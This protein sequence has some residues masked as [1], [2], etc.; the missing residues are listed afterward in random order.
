MS[1][2]RAAFLAALFASVLLAIPTSLDAQRTAG[3]TVSAPP[4]AVP[5]GPLRPVAVRPS[6]G[7]RVNGE[8]HLNHAH[9]SANDV[10]HQQAQDQ[11][12]TGLGAGA[13]VDLQQLLNITPTNGF[14]WQYV[15][16]INQDLP[17][18]AIVDPVTRLEIAQAEQLLRIGGG[19][20]SG[21]YILDGGYGYY[22]P[23]ETADQQTPPN[24]APANAEQPPMEAQDPPENTEPRV[25]V[26]QQNSQESTPPTIPNDGEFTLVL[27][28]GQKIAAV[29]FTRVSNEIVYITP[30]GT[31]RTIDASELD[32]AATVRLNQERGTP[33]QLPG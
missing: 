30:D 29:A 32:S 22:V 5:T 17:L 25:I 28:N 31:R 14:D 27:R 15:N 7:V 9:S 10:A 2:S 8:R 18:K 23:E 6:N 20:F 1:K 4:R 3:R 26:L 21:A 24:A 33:L 16:A 13:P 12:G 19:Q 11:Y